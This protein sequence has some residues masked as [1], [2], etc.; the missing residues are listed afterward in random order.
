[1]NVPKSLPN[2]AVSAVWLLH[3]AVRVA[4]K[5]RGSCAVV[6]WELQEWH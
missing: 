1:M 4:L 2:I 6:V 5:Q 3:V